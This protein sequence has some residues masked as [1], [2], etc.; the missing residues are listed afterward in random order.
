MNE[1]L[2]NTIAELLNKYG[3]AFDE[4]KQWTIDTVMP[5]IKELIERIR[6]YNIVSCSVLILISLFF[7]IIS[8]LFM[9][10]AFKEYKEFK[11]TEKDNLFFEKSYLENTTPTIFFIIGFTVTLFVGLLSFASIITNISDLLSWIFI[12]DLQFIEYI[13]TVIGA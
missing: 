10:K 4:T 7:I 5:Y 8:I 11:E 12:P 3:I 9:I 1:N 6:T 2:Q 13:S